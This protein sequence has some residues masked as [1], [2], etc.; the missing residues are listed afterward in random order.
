MENMENPVDTNIKTDS[1]SKTDGSESHPGLNGLFENLPDSAKVI[2]ENLSDSGKEFATKIFES[3]ETQSDKVLGRVGIAFNQFWIEKHEGKSTKIHEKI[4]GLDEK[5]S[6]V[7]DSTSKISASIEVLKNRGINTDKFERQIENNRI[8]KEAL[9]LKRE[10]QQMRYENREEKKNLFVSRRNE[11]VDRLIGYQ[12]ERLN[13]I[14]EKIKKMNNDIDK[15]RFNLQIDRIK[16]I[17]REDDLNTIT[18]TREEIREAYEE[19]GMSKWRIRRNEALRDL[20]RE[21]KSARKASDKESEEITKGREELLK[22]KE[23]VVKKEQKTIPYRQRISKLQAIRRSNTNEAV[24][25]AVEDPMNENYFFS[26]FQPV[27]EKI[28][29][30]SKNTK[31]NDRLLTLGEIIKEW[32][33]NVDKTNLLDHESYRALAHELSEHPELSLDTRLTKGA[34]KSTLLSFIY[35]TNKYALMR[36]GTKL[37]A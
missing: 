23:K 22:K 3:I 21:I 36:Y 13:P 5:I 37:Y 2:L 26:T 30:E 24:E 1:D 10:Q 31:E 20:D 28:L 4:E 16:H 19:S 29:P 6:K 32:D 9:T 25:A 12:E 11:I 15:E 8:K 18:K 35:M 7:D 33:T 34:F 17:E 27:F 14:N